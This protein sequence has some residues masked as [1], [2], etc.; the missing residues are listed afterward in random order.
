METSLLAQ[1]VVLVETILAVG[2][3]RIYLTREDQDGWIIERAVAGLMTLI[4]IEITLI[5]ITGEVP[6]WLMWIIG[7]IYLVGTIHEL[8]GGIRGK[9]WAVLGLF[10]SLVFMFLAYILSAPARFLLGRIRTRP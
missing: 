3:Y 8:L 2:L 5:I 4:L 6:F 1:L 7:P 9:Y 10:L